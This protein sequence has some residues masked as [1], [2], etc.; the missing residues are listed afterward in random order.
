LLY[1]FE[2][3]NYQTKSYIMAE[4]KTKQTAAS[5]DKFL[6]TVKFPENKKKYLLKVFKEYKPKK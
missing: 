4:L 1:Y 2:T 3:T 5:V 6:K